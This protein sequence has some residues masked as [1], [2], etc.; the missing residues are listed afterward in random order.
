MKINNIDIEKAMLG[1]QEI[2]AV[3][4]NGTNIH[5]TFDPLTDLAEL[6]AFNVVAIS[7]TQLDNLW[8]IP[9]E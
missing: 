1:G 3:M 7:P 5:D 8:V 4:F 9:I 2:S 6:L